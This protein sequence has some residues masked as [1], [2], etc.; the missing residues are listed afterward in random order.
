MENSLPQMAGAIDATRPRLG[1]GF[2]EWLLTRWFRDIR[3]GR[4]TVELPSGAQR[5]FV[6]ETPGPRAQLAIRDLRL[7]TRMIFGGDVGFAEGYMEGDWDTPDLSALLALGKLNADALDKV[8]GRHALV[9]LASRLRHA[10]RANTRRGS[11]RNIAAHYDLGNDFYRAWL[12]PSMTYS[13]A[14]FAD[15]DEPM[16]DAQRRKYLR[17]AQQLDLKPGQRILE[18]GCGWGGFA[19]IAAAEFGC[20]VIGLTLSTEQAAFARQRMARTGLSEQVEIRI[21]DYRDVEG[22]FDHVVSIEMFEA[23]GEKFWPTYLDTLTRRLKPGGRAALQVITI[24]D[25]KYHNYRRNPDFIQN[26]IFP[27]GMLPSPDAFADAVERAGLRFI[28]GFFFGP[29]YAETLRRWDRDFREHWPQI[30]EQGFDQRFYRMWHYY[31]RY[32]EVGFDYGTID[33]GQ[34]VIERP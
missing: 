14:L 21:Q 19:E 33:V 4:L 6:G 20:T 26:Y 15:L 22:T 3:V 10:G 32:C 17:L 30:A 16:A 25:D 12:D 13:S 34:F 8:L 18:I 11:R 1:A 28:D 29:S 5:V 27:G 2:R 7:V 9:N 23:V 31:L 24:D